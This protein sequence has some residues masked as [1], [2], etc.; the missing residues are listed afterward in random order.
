MAL[1]VS[2]IVP[3]RFQTKFFKAKL[4]TV[5]RCLTYSCNHSHR[6][7]QICSINIAT[8]AQFS[9]PS[10]LRVHMDKLGEKIWEALPEPVKEFPWRR[11]EDIVIQQLLLLGKK[12]LKWSLITAFVLS[13][14]SDIIFSIS[15]NRELLIPIGLSV[16]CM[17]AEFLKETSGE[18]FQEAKKGDL[19]WQLLGIGSFFVLVKLISVY[20]MQERA[21]LSHVGNGGFMHV[22]W[23]WNKNLRGRNGDDENS[24]HQDASIATDV[25]G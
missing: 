19:A 6:T 5:R 3:L 1:A 15:R 25:L 4:Y 16:G 22:L 14:L 7:S 18:L 11:A 12:A 24:I 2:A 10:K 8:M 17:M 13:S 9:D 21:F 23:L 20:F